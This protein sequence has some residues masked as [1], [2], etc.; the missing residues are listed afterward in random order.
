MMNEYIE[1]I[2]ENAKRTFG[3]TNNI[4][5]GGYILTDG[6]I[7]NFSHEGYIRDTD[8]RDIDDAMPEN[9]FETKIDAMIAFINY[10]NI[11]IN[12]YGFETAVMPNQKQIPAIEKII[13]HSRAK[14]T[15]LYVD[16]ADKNGKIIKSIAY[17]KPLID[18]VMNDLNKFFTLLQ[19]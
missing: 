5:L 10:G 9:A 8:H 3:L 14:N 11:R 15:G 12:T 4:A 1:Q 18:D 17:E 13:M 7:L 19:M 6:S 2:N 16:I